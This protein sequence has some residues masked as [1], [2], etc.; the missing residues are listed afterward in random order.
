MNNFDG[1]YNNVIIPKLG[2]F[3]NKCDFSFSENPSPVA[4][5]K[6]ATKGRVPYLSAKSSS[7]VGNSEYNAKHKYKSIDLSRVWHIYEEESYGNKKM[8]QAV[9]DHI[10]AKKENGEIYL[11]PF[12]PCYVTANNYDFASEAR[13]TF[14]IDFI[15]SKVDQCAES[16]DS[17]LENDNVSDEFI[18]DLIKTLIELGLVDNLDVLRNILPDYIVKSHGEDLKK[19][20]Y[21][22]SQDI[23]NYR[24]MKKDIKEFAMLVDII[25]NPTKENAYSMRYRTD[26]VS[27][28][29]KRTPKSLPKKLIQLTFSPAKHVCVVMINYNG[30]E[31]N[32]SYDTHLCY[33]PYE[34]MDSYK[35]FADKA[36][37]SMIPAEV[38]EKPSDKPIHRVLDEEEWP[39]E[40]RDVI[41]NSLNGSVPVD[42]FYES[43]KCARE[44]I[45]INTGRDLRHNFSHT[46][47]I[48]ICDRSLCQ[49]LTKSMKRWSPQKSSMR[50]Q[51]L[52]LWKQ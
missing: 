26:A 3:V 47:E 27:I 32:Y 49:F 23:L 13:R 44:Y 46:I 10:L 41:E 45:P 24:Y 6:H 15:N 14:M 17:Y 4:I 11:T 40:V 29:V 42:A 52:L 22:K 39:T 7:I 43:L 50:R 37:E 30:Q 18:Y 12:G 28:M 25:G 31:F 34:F 9:G 1:K 21:L 51:G 16:N 36:R 38:Q 2:D 33:N 48:I 5:W 35:T 19:L 20:E 8:F